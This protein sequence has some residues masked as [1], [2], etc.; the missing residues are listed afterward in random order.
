MYFY[1]SNFKSQTALTGL[2]LSCTDTDCFVL[3]PLLLVKSSFSSVFLPV[4]NLV[5]LVFSLVFLIFL[6]FFLSSS[7]WSPSSWSPSSWPPSSWS[8][9]VSSSFSSAFAAWSS[10][11]SPSSCSSSCSLSPLSSP[12]SSSSCSCSS[13]S[14]QVL[15]FHQFIFPRKTFC[16]PRHDTK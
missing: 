3:P 4:F 11:P 2:E 12:C 8:P 5:F 14:S 10:S 6:L 13:P 16:Y 9:S 1:S 15:V 7:S